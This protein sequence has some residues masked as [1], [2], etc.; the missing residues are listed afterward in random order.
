MFFSGTWV[1]FGEMTMTIW[2]EMSLKNWRLNIFEQM[3]SYPS[4]FM[5]PLI[6]S[7]KMF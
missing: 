1:F 6:K 3:S 5:D 7:S 2:K 4:F